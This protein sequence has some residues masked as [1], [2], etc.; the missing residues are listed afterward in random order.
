M[1]VRV[2]RV[3]T[4]D[5]ESLSVDCSTEEI[6]HIETA[7]VPDS[8]QDDSKRAV[9]NG[10]ACTRVQGRK[11]FEVLHQIV[12]RYDQRIAPPAVSGGRI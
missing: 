1:Q 12:R 8:P 5:K 4:I 11:S 2:E 7:L 6:Q 3:D 10:T 9:E